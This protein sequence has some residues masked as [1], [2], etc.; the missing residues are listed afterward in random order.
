ML[1]VAGRNA[2]RWRVHSESGV[3]VIVG[4][5]QFWNPGRGTSAVG[6]RYPR[7]TFGTAGHEGSVSV[8]VDL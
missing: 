2:T 8:I 5:G 3:A 1:I 6:S 4:R 7:A